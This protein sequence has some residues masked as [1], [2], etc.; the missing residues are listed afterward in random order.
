MSL[1]GHGFPV[2]GREPSGPG[3]L[4]GEPF[5]GLA[6]FLDDRIITMPKLNATLETSIA[7][8]QSEPIIRSVKVTG[9]SAPVLPVP[10]A[11][12]PVQPRPSAHA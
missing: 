10:M 5:L 1:A 4:V 12:P 11:P 9:V 7:Q 2:A 8:L 3:G 6:A